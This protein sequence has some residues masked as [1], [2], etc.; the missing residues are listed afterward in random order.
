MYNLTMHYLFCV[1][2]SCS[3]S[4]CPKFGKH[5]CANIQCGLKHSLVPLIYNE[6]SELKKPLLS[7]IKVTGSIKLVQ[8]LIHF[9][10]LL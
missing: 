7:E 5:S 8:S 9:Y 3:A 2:C 6:G 4:V 1:I 10:V